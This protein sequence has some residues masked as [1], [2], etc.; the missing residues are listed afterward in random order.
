M[1]SETPAATDSGEQPGGSAT[2]AP[3]RSSAQSGDERLAHLTRAVL[4]LPT[5]IRDPAG[6]A[7]CQ[8]PFTDAKLLAFVISP[9]VRAEPW[10][11]YR[12]LQDTQPVLRTGFGAWIVSR[13]RDVAALSRQSGLSVEEAKATQPLAFG[14][15]EDGPFSRLMDR[16]MLFVDP[17]DHERLRRLV[18]GAFTPRRVEELRPRVKDLTRARLDTLAAGGEG[19]LLRDLAYPLPVDVICELLGIPAADRDRFPTLAKALAAR[20]DVQPVRTEQVNRDGDAAAA[21]FVAY[22]QQLLADPG[23][24]APGGLIEALATAED[25]GDRLSHDEVISTCALLLIAG[26]ETTANLIANSIVALHRH[27]D[28]LD[29][30]RSGAVAIDTAVEELLRHDGPVQLTQRIT[31]SAIE[32]EGGTIPA[33]AVVVLLIGAANRDPRV[34]DQPDKLDLERSPN[35]HLSF[36]SGIHACLGA[37]LARMETSVVL[38]ELLER[39]TH[40]RLMGRPAWRE[41]FVIRGL[42]SLPVTW[43]H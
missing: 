30:V 13:H 3:S 20:L 2:Q 6:R 37:H 16:T 22:L 31:I 5:G 42:K 11:L 32:L 27:P 43:Q 8:L 28:Q 12:R 40:L 34:F 10:A 15:P 26:H 41:T 7:L 36:S 18:S 21:E 24:R 23:R 17:P 33:G 38:G 29:A 4:G 1:A 39:W 14:P 25:G 9:R 35:P 19:D